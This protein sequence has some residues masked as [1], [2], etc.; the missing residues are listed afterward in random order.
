MYK[1]G[2]STCGNKAM[3]FEGFLAMNAAGMQATEICC[4]SYQDIDFKKIKADADAAGIE[5]FSIHSHMHP[6]FDISSLDKS[7]NERAIREFST[8][9]DR[10]SDIEIDK[11]VIH[12][13]HTP[14][15]FDQKERGEKIK[16]AMTCLDLLAEHAH[17]KGVRIAVENLP[18]TCLAN[19]LDEH[20][21]ILSANDKL[22]ACLD[23]NH[24]LIDDTVTIIEK[25]GKKIITIH[26]S[27]R[28]SVNERHWL[29][30]EGVLDWKKIIDAFQS[31]GYRGA[32]IYEVG[33]YPSSTIERR[34]LTY[35]D[36][37]I[38][39]KEIFAKD[40]ITVIGRPYPNLGLWGP[41]DQE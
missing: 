24:S 12:P 7:S 39:A 35:R 17:K 21:H 36:F 23:L 20:L 16:H 3:D 4:S 30:G 10:I 34:A 2:I 32:W 40:D 38:N 15:P 29:P 33:F 26:V 11:I 31:I 28:D 5:L 27:D 9:I 1:I 22:F 25:L 13:T 41:R 37:V 18:R 14:E 6:S 8:L 19:T